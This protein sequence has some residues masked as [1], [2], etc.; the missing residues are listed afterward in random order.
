MHEKA[1][2]NEALKCP[3]S[4]LRFQ[5]GRVDRLESSIPKSHLRPQSISLNDQRKA[6]G[7]VDRIFYSMQCYPE[8]LLSATNVPVNLR[9]LQQRNRKP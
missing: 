2:C 6:F 7:L 9:N 8:F 4:T 3:L 1:L 5:L